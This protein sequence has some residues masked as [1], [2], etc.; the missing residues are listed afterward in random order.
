[1]EKVVG[2]LPDPLDGSIHLSPACYIYNFK[3]TRVYTSKP[4]LSRPSKL[5]IREKRSRIIGKLEEGRSVTSVAAEFEL[6]KASFHDFGDNFKLQEQL[7]GFQQWS[8]TRK[9]TPQM[10]GILSYRPE[11]TGGRQRRNPLDTTQSTGR[12]ISFYSGQK[13]ARWWS[14]CT[15]PCTVCVPLTPAHRRGV[16]C[17]AGNTVIGETMKGGRVLFTNESRFSLSSDSHL[18]RAGNPQSSLEHHSKGQVWRSR[19]SR[20]GGI[21]LGSHTDLHIFDAGSDPTGPSYC[22]EILLPYVRLL[23]GAMG[24]QFLFMDDKLHVITRR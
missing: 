21:M 23:E 16:L 19:C 2:I 4:L 10:T 9:T 22:N 6:L 13:T 12:P 8:S 20:W 15:T 14:V 17:G 11:E 1:M 5:T 3:S 7:S 18:E 24:V